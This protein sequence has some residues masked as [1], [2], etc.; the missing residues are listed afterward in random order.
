MAN[1]NVIAEPTQPA[2]ISPI[3][4][5]VYILATHRTL[6]FSKPSVFFGLL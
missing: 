3:I 5:T 4:M 2:D 6:N 1:L